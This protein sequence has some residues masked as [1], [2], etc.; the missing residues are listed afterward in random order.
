MQQ[1]IFLC[2]EGNNLVK[3]RDYR[4]NDHG[5]VCGY[6]N[7]PQEVVVYGISTFGLSGDYGFADALFLVICLPVS[8]WCMTMP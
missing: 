5:L 4:L 8:S 2:A 3:D 6:G 1:P 7:K